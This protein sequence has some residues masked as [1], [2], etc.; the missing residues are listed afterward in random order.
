MGDEEGLADE[1]IEFAGAEL[2]GA[3]EG[4]RVHDE[5]EIILIVLDLRVHAFRHRVLDRERVKLEDVLQDALALLGRRLRQVDPD[6]Q[7]LVGT[8]QPQRVDVQIGPDQFTVVKNKGV[9]HNGG[10]REM[11]GATLLL[12]LW[13]SKMQELSRLDL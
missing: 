4:D 8:D 3:A 2:V 10:K 1:K 11:A 9:D 13:R 6:E 7:A 12:S 5:V